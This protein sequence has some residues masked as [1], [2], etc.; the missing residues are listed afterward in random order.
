M[1]APGSNNKLTLILL[2]GLLC[3]ETIWVPVARELA[4]ICDIRIIHFTGFSSIEAMAAH[5]LN[6]SAGPFFLAGHSM[7]GRVALEAYRQ[8]PDRVLGLA[9]LNTGVHARSPGEREKRERLVRLARTAGMRVLADE[10]LPP[11]MDAH[12]KGDPLLMEELETM[13]CRATSDSFAGQIQALLDRP[14]AESI[15]REI[16]VPTLLLSATGD[17]WS[18]PDQHRSM[19]DL[20]P[21]ARLVII[22]GAGHMAPVEQPEAVAMALRDWLTRA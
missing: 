13:V 9:L 19:L 20:V 10:W 6:S 7:G 16:S 4:D 8:A 5:V 18:P 14:A 12:G 22:E 17:T 1:N 3:D 21:H 11:M 2:A 15:L